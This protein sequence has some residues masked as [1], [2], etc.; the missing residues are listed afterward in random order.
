[1]AFT[2]CIFEAKRKAAIS[3]GDNSRKPKSFYKKECRSTK[4][5]FKMFLHVFRFLWQD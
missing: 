1:M 5:R 4:I 2:V 3:G